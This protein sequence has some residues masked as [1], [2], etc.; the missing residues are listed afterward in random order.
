MHMRNSERSYKVRVVTRHAYFFCRRY[1]TVFFV[2][3]ELVPRIYF[4]G[5]TF[6]MNCRLRSEI[7]TEKAED[8]C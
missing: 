2:V 3:K 8:S 1:F 7:S 4:F 6:L 5:S